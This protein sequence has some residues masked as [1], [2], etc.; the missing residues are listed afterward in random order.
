MKKKK[1]VLL[2]I[3]LLMINLKTSATQ[4]ITLEPEEVMERANIIVVGQYDFSKDPMRTV[5]RLYRPY[6]FRISKTIKGEPPSSLLAG[7]YT[8]DISRMIEFQAEGGEFLLFLEKESYSKYALPV[9]GPNG[10]LMLMDGELFQPGFN[11]KALYELVEQDIGSPSVAGPVV[12]LLICFSLAALL[13]F[14]R[15]YSKD[16]CS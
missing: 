16:Y 9:G 4:W 8:Q 10:T 11:H 7:I 2:T 1:I 12:I 15:L 6:E 3:L 14:K 13:F 5:R